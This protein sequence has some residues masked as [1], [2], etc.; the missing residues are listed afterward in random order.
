MGWD[1]NPRE[2]CTPAGFQDRCLKPLGHPSGSEH[3]RFGNDRLRR[4]GRCHGIA[5]RSRRR[6]CF[7]KR[8]AASRQAAIGACAG[9][10][11]LIWSGDTSVMPPLMQDTR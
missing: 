7:G 9:A 8:D 4:K 6:V 10:Q 11:D 5:R 1:S 2:A 3:Q